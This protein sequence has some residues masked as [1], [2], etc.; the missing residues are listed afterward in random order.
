MYGVVCGFNDA[1][2]DL[3]RFMVDFV[4]N[5]RGDQTME[6]MD[7]LKRNLAERVEEARVW[8]R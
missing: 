1:W 4:R 8:D 3:D 2:K 7:F 6:P 5:S